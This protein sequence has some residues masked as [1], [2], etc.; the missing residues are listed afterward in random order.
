MT[1][2]T[3]RIWWNH[4]RFRTVLGLRILAAASAFVGLVQM[5]STQAK[6][7]GPDFDWDSY[8]AMTTD[9]LTF[10]TSSTYP[11]LDV[12]AVWEYVL[13]FGILGTILSFLPE[14]VFD[15]HSLEEE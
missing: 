7:W 1:A 9:M 5:I 6:V 4:D 15:E 11:L 14:V 2:V 12:A 3:V 13:V 10:C 8:N